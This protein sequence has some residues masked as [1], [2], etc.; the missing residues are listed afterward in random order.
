M[1]G[2]L[3]Y[4]YR[5][6]PSG[7]IAV[8]PTAATVVCLVLMSA[9]LQRFGVAC[10]FIRTICPDLSSDAV[11]R[12]ALRI[13]SH[14]PWY[15]L[16]VARQDLTPDAR[17]VIAGHAAVPFTMCA[18]TPTAGQGIPAPHPRLPWRGCVVSGGRQS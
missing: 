6:R 1:A 8:D 10:V 14:A 17:L 16:G 5:R 12:L 9:P 4:G 2:R 18:P 7:E 15:R 13:R 11:K 3:L